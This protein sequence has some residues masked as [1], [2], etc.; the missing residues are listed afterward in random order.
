MTITAAEQYFIELTNRA[1]LDPVGEAAL[2]KVALN[3]G[4]AAGTLGT[5]VRQVLAPDEAL[6]SAAN[7]HS[8]WMLAVDQFSHA[9]LNGSTP[10]N[11][12]SDAGYDWDTVGENI[13]WRGTTA[14][15][16]LEKIIALQHEDLFKSAHH[17]A[18][19]LLDRFSE[20]GVSQEAGTFKSGATTFNAAMLTENFGT[21]GDD[22]FITGVAYNDTSKDNF[23][24]IGEGTAGVTL[25]AQGITDTTKAA[26]GYALA[27]AAGAA[28]EVKGRVGALDFSATVAL[29][30]GNVK[31]DVVNGSTIFTSGDIKL[32]SGL[33]D[34]R[35]LGAAE[36]TAEGNAFANVITGNKAANVVSGAAGA[37]VIWGGLG[38]DSLYGGAD[39]DKLY[40]ELGADVLD[41]GAGAD[42]ILG[43]AGLDRLTGGTGADVLT[44]GLD[45][46][47]FVFMN[48]DGA[49]R[50]TD[51]GVKAR[52][53]LLLDD[54]LW[55]G[56]ALT[57]AQVVKTYARVT[58][59]VVVFN[60]G[61]GDVLTLAAV[62]TLTGLA[63]VIDII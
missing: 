10:G 33:N 40:G 60:F 29:D 38:A 59:G 23:Y 45:K 43:G 57:E 37:D 5:Q 36:L 19:I 32:G 44:G 16:N 26:G 2:Y 35:L 53:I 28:V 18:N 11:R 61:E 12:V 15:M 25:T 1:R 55:G 21:S 63:A 17:R 46:D 6:E 54:A 14:V 24:S 56:A 20:I 52:E 49:D 41:G 31:F 51:F 27:L 34:V 48:G 3:Q 7:G 13:T 4:L 8:L 30:N 50:I 42:L 58:G 47:T 22:V 39:A 62:K 9:G